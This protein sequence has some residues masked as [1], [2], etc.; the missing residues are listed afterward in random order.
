[1]ARNNIMSSWLCSKTTSSLDGAMTGACVVRLSC[2][3]SRS[4]P[5]SLC[6]YRRLRRS[7]ELLWESF[8]TE[9]LCSSNRQ[10]VSVVPH[11]ARPT[12][13]AVYVR[14]GVSTRASCRKHVL[15]DQPFGEKFLR[16]VSPKGTRMV[17]TQQ[18]SVRVSTVG[19]LFAVLP[20][21]EL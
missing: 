4:G 19:K 10:E 20:S 12:H 2:F 6:S 18:S 3:G 1:M 8:R 15:Y 11:G 13:V 7:A 14:E 9:S 17:K 16:I 21:R 5:E